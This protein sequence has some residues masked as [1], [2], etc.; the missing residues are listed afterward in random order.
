MNGRFIQN[1]I[2][3]CL[4]VSNLM[5]PYNNRVYMRQLGTLQT[6]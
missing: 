2:L 5:L 1:N 3:Y 4:S 6:H